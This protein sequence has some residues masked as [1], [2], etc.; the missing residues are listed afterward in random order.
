MIFA[1]PA[2]ASDLL[3]QVDERLGALVG[4]IEHASCS[5]VALGYPRASAKHSLDAFGFVVP[6]AEKRRVIACSLAS[7]K[8]PQRAPDDRVLFRVFIG[9][10]MQPKL[11]ALPD[12][13]LLTLARDELQDLL[14]V[15]GEPEIAEVT[16]WTHVMPQYH[17][18]HLDL[19]AQIESCSAAIPRFALAGNAFRGVG[20]PFCI[21]SGEQAAELVAGQLT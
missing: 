16:R 21:R 17:V 3:R 20:L 14:G 18:G 11:A 13:E 19:V 8:F 2:T 5:V 7:V 10:A 15:T 6:A 4:Q 9:G 12:D 1:L